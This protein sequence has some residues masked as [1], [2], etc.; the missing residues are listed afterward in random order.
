MRIPTPQWDAGAA[1][2]RWADGNTWT[3]LAPDI[4][5]CV[6]AAAPHCEVRVV[7][8]RGGEGAGFAGPGAEGEVVVRGGS[9]MRGY[10]GDNA[11]TV[12]AFLPGGGPANPGAWLRTGDLGR[13]D[14]AGR[15]WLSGRA[16]DVIRTGAE[17]VH[18]AEVERLLRRCPGVADAAVVGLPHARLG[19]QVAALVQ[20]DPGAAGVRVDAAAVR[21]HCRQAGCA[22][23]K[24]PRVVVAVPEALPRRGIG[25][26]DRSRVRAVLLAARR[27]AERGEAGGGEQRQPRS[28]L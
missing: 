11:A 18:P 5:A 14:G 26:V 12:A 3:K 25:K 9:V 1:G 19:E 22:G 27:D 8:R 17:T 28:K 16:K 4:G 21:A 7:L 2:I 10:L 20:S 23:Y 24:V 15:L 13:L 6:G